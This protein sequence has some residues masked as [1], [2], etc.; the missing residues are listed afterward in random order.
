MLETAMASVDAS[1][2]IARNEPF[3][4]QASI[5]RFTLGSFGRDVSIAARASGSFD[6]AA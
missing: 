6:L 2:S 5:G 1:T 4:K 3:E